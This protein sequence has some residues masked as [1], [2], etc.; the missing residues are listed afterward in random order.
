MNTNNAFCY[1]PF[2]NLH[3]NSLGDINPCCINGYTSFGNIN[4]NSVD[5]ILNGEKIKKFKSDMLSG[6]VHTGCVDCINA[7]KNGM[8]SYRQYFEDIVRDENILVDIQGKN[9]IHYVDLRITNKCNLRCRM[10]VPQS[11][12]LLAQDMKKLGYN[13]SENELKNEPA[14][15]FDSLISELGP[16][17]DN[18]KIVYLAGGEPSIMD[19]QY[20]FIDY[21]I[22]KDLAKKIKLY[23][24]SNINLRTLRYGNR[25]YVELLKNFKQV[26]FTVSIDGIHERGEYI[27]K[28]LNYNTWKENFI[29]L[30]DVQAKSNGKFKVNTY[31]TIAM[32]NLLH[33]FDMIVELLTLNG[34]NPDS[35]SLN[36]LSSPIFYN[37]TVLP[38][39][40]KNKFN[41]SLEI[42]MS[43]YSDSKYE[44]LHKNLISIKNHVF[45]KNEVN[46]IPN[47]FNFNEKL[48][49]LRNEDFF[50]FFPELAELSQYK[51]ISSLT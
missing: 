20:M 14:K 4:N 30:M 36:P 13:V 24:T 1:A 3:I 8:H 15:D 37:S 27:R 43:K 12:I 32:Y 21:L 44:N 31:S 38:T 47:F 26:Y 48:D 40:I 39:N 34:D 10:C 2:I 41:D 25:D 6:I 9:D 19:E 49:K 51:S 50:Q 16:M 11:S 28:N 45:S 33:V 5:D 46:L 29:Y 7:E 42:F 35:I 23:C 18:L 17:L 22:E